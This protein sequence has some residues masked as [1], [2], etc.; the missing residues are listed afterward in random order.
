MNILLHIVIL[1]PLARDF[2]G[3]PFLLLFLIETHFYV[4]IDKFSSN[5]PLIRPNQKLVFEYTYT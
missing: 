1:I 3:P 5:I 2:F 4:L